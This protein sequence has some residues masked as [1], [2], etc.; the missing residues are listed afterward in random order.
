MNVGEEIAL[1]KQTVPDYVRWF[2]T[3]GEL[4]YIPLEK[5][6][7]SN[8][9]IIDG[10]FGTFLPSNVLDLA[11][12]VLKNDISSIISGI[13]LLSWCTEE[14]EERYYLEKLRKTW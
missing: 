2:K 7:T 9:G 5:L 12:K 6:T 14:E 3:G 8:T 11:Y 13:A 1:I 10:T 4:H